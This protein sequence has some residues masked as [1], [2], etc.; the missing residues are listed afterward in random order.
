MGIYEIISHEKSGKFME[1]IAKLAVIGAGAWGTAIAILLAQNGHEVRLW[2]RREE[3][4]REIQQ[5]RVNKTY[6]PDMDFPDGLEVS[7]KKLFSDTLY[8]QRHK[9]HQP[10]NPPTLFSHN[11]NPSTQHHSSRTF[12][13]KPSPR[14]RQRTTSRNHYCL[15]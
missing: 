3:F 8:H 1:N 6:L 4:A 2:A 12:W 14:N 15:C 9:R 13:T 5:E 11:Q 7:P 10:P